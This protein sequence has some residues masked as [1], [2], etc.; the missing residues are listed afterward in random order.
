MECQEVACSA[1]WHNPSFSF[2]TPHTLDFIPSIS[3]IY[4][5][6]NGISMLKNG[7]FLLKGCSWIMSKRM[8]K[9][10]ME[11][12][13]AKQCEQSEHV[14]PTESCSHHNISDQAVELDWQTVFWASGGQDCSG[15]RRCGLRVCN[16]NAGCS[17]CVAWKSLSFHLVVQPWVVWI[18]K[19]ILVVNNIYTNAKW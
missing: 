19:S 3:Y 16:S 1:S 2:N 6:H 4:N 8:Q 7:E 10:Q 9:R 18:N 17:R 14:G 12:R 13:L 11:L 5:Q 15:M